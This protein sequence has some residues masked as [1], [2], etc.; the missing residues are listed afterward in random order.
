MSAHLDRKRWALLIF[1]FVQVVLVCFLLIFSQLLLSLWSILAIFSDGFT[2]DTHWMNEQTN[3][4]SDEIHSR[5]KSLPRCRPE[6]ILIGSLGGCYLRLDI[7]IMEVSRSNCCCH[8]AVAT[9][10]DADADMHWLYRFKFFGEW[11]ASAHAS[12]HSHAQSYQNWTFR[13]SVDSVK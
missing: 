1:F 2:F 11:R 3:G 12:L 13:Q 10:V 7:D 5:L 9:V 8:T 6:M 4:N